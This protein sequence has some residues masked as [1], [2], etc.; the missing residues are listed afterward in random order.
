M[1]T[2]TVT[3]SKTHKQAARTLVRSMLLLGTMQ[4]PAACQD[5]GKAS[6]D[7]DG[8]HEDYSKPQDVVWVCPACHGKRHRK[9]PNGKPKAKR[10]Y[11]FK[12]H[13][14]KGI[15]FGKKYTSVWLEVEYVKQIHE[16]CQANK[17]SVSDFVRDAILVKLGIGTTATPQNHF[18]EN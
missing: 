18:P 2:A 11:R 13:A 8:H 15:R 5:C 17:M 3:F 1:S 4:K 7:L 6:G 16:I 14:T 9:Y 12:S 10:P